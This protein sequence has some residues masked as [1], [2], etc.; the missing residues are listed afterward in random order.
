MRTPT[1]AHQSHLQGRRTLWDPDAGAVDVYFAAPARL[2]VRYPPWSIAMNAAE[3]MLA[4]IAMP[5]LCYR[6]IHALRARLSPACDGVI[7]I[8]HAGLAQALGV[9]RQ[10]ITEAITALRGHGIILRS[11]RGRI[12]LSPWIGW[13]GAMAH[14]RRAQSAT[15]PP[16]RLRLIR[17]TPR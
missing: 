16:P 17:P 2:P 8:T 3:E 5:A 6:L 4:Q 14:G 11:G 9:P 12:R 13:S 7:D 1:N 15:P 10:R